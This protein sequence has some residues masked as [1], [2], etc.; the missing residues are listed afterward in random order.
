[1][2]LKNEEMKKVYAVKEEIMYKKLRIAIAQVEA[3]LANPE[4]NKKRIVS[5]IKDAASQ[6]ANMICFPELY[7]TGYDV[8]GEALAKYAIHQDDVF[9][10][11]MKA[12]AQEYEIN[13]LMS[14]PEKNHISDKPYIAYAFITSNGELVNNHRKTYLWGTENDKVLPGAAVYNTIETS[15]GTIGTLICY[16]IEFPE[17]ARILTLKGAEIII[18]TAAFDTVRNFHNYISA[19]GILNHVYAIGVNGCRLGEEPSRG[20]SCIADQKGR[21]VYELPAGEEA[22]GIFDIDLNE[23]NRRK[24]EPHMKDLLIDTLKQIGKI[25]KWN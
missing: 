6:G 16:E 3:T 8:S 14:Y 24:E 21:I 12:M 10:D 4:D 1:M 13:I 20:G 23:Y 19:I 17:P 9:F 5:L 11:Q 25:D 7:Y 2:R 15:F 18:A 22:L